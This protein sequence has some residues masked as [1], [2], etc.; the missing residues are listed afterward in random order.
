MH[1]TF[2]NP[3]TSEAELRATLG[4]PAEL[5][6]NKTLD[7]LD[8]HCRTFIENSPFLTIA[9]SDGNGHFDVSPKGDPPGFVKILDDRTLAIPD[10][11]GNKRADTLTNVLRNPQVGLLF[12]I[13]G[14]RETLRVNGSATVVRDPELLQ[15]LAVN[16]RPALFATVVTVQEAFL[17]CAKCMIRSKLWTAADPDRVTKIA[18]LGT[19]LVEQAKLDITPE[20]MDEMIREDERENLY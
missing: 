13:P 14:V 9:S 20:E 4:Y 8:D 19:S 10:R 7:Y 1:P 11:P 18:S 15:L 17:H 5:V 16:D 2:R 12:L 3:V 6:V